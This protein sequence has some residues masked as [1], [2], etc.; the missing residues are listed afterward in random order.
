MKMEWCFVLSHTDD[1]LLQSSRTRNTSDKFSCG[2]LHK[3]HLPSYCCI[4]FSTPDVCQMLIAIDLQCG[5]VTKKQSLPGS[6]LPTP[7]DGKCC[8]SILQFCLFLTLPTVTEVCMTLLVFYNDVPHHLLRDLQ[9]LACIRG[10]V[11]GWQV[12]QLPQAPLLRGPCASGLWVC[13]AI[14][15]GKLEMLIHAPFKILQGQIP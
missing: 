15:S 3:T 13:Q 12:G 11:W 5:I 10:G 14:F 6:C 9:V 7:C 4:N 1:I 8:R 2:S